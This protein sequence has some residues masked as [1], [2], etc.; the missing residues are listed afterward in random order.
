M[1]LQRNK[2]LPGRLR[3]LVAALLEI[4]LEQRPRS[5]RT[6]RR[7]AYPPGIARLRDRETTSA[8]FVFVL[9]HKLWDKNYTLLIFALKIIILTLLWG[10]F[11]S[12]KGFLMASH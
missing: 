1:K 4:E 12:I 8:I 2:P 5:R 7:R 9:E 10:F 11:Y 6:V 3:R